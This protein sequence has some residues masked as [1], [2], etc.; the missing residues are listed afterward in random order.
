MGTLSE[1]TRLALWYT[2]S[3]GSLGALHPFFA[4][5]LS[6]AGAN[7]L[8]IAGVLGLFPLGILF[9][10]PLWAAWAD[11]L[12]DPRKVVFI[13]AIGTATAG[14]MLLAPGPW[15]WL[16]P[17]ALLLA[18]CRTPL[19]AV[20]DALAVDRLG[21]ERY[22]RVRLWGSVSFV[23]IVQLTGH[24]RDLWPRAPLVVTLLLFLGMVGWSR[25]LPEPRR[26]PPVDWAAALRALRD[27]PVLRPLAGIAVLHGAT[28]SMYDHMYGLHVEA[29]GFDSG[30]LGTAVGVGVVAE[31]AVMWA[32]APLLR[33]FGGLGL[34]SM[35]V[36]ASLPR[37]WGTAVVSD[38][39]LQVALQSLHGLTFGAWWIGG[40]Q[41]FAECAPEGLEN[42]SQSILLASSFGVGSIFAMISTGALLDS[43]GPQ[44]L[45]LASAVVSAVAIALLARFAWGRRG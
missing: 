8:V 28:L 38:P 20:V 39:V 41:L 37:W 11:R 44:V 24:A 16:L 6:D 4:P 33:R 13:A 42:T 30:L 25:A 45:F 2:L 14:A 32:G 36:V 26:V 43:H 19:F 40:V 10:G 12:G 29:L 15:T 23:A 18:I 3:V 22:G 35:A 27:H 7:G 5:I 1:S 31:I 34:M 17:G 21:G 9:I